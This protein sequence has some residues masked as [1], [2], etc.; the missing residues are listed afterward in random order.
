MKQ[1][2]CGLF[3]TN[4]SSVHSIILMTKKDYEDWINHKIAVRFIDDYDEQTWGRT[5]EVPGL[6]EWGNSSVI[7]YNYDKVSMEERID[8]T[9]DVIEKNLDDEEYPGLEEALKIIKTT[10]AKNLPESILKYGGFELLYLTPE[11]FKEAITSSDCT[12]L[13][14]G[15]DNDLVLIGNYYHS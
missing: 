3:E 8:A 5:A 1:I 10:N 4:S 11:E 7:G 13:F 14:S 6:E 15:Y 2:R 12:F 9:I